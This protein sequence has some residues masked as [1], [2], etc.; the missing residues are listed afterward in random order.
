MKVSDFWHPERG[1]TYKSVHGLMRISLV[2][3]I[4]VPLIAP[5][6]CFS[7]PASGVI[8]MRVCMHPCAS[9]SA[10]IESE[11]NATRRDKN[12]TFESQLKFLIPIGVSNGKSGIIAL[13]ELRIPFQNDGRSIIKRLV[14]FC[15]LWSGMAFEGGRGVGSPPLASFHGGGTRFDPPHFLAES[16]GNVLLALKSFDVLPHCHDCY[17]DPS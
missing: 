17:S 11:I 3:F 15:S 4:L 9:L 14:G 1:A 5:T 2:V 7:G 12:R 6:L 16:Y 10:C 8:V 13:T